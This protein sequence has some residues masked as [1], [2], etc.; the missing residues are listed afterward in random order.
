MACEPN[1][2]GS[3]LIECD[4]GRARGAVDGHTVA[5][6]EPIVLAVGQHTVTVSAPTYRTVSKLVEVR[7][8]ETTKL[9]TKLQPSTLD[10]IG[11]AWSYWPE[12]TMGAGG[13]TLVTSVI[14]GILTMSLESEMQDSYR[15]D[16]KR[17]TYYVR[18]SDRGDSLALATNITLI[19]GSVLVTTGF[20]AWLWPE[21]SGQ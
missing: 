16:A 15:A 20:V 21:E 18:A 3:L 13:A 1:T 7:F 14:L 5:I 6:G 4:V 19:A 8:D 12:I 11:D 9:N 17:D 2:Q 10:V